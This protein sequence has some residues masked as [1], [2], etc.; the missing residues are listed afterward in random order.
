[1]FKWIK[2]MFSI[3][4][5]VKKVAATEPKVTVRYAP[6][7]KRIVECVVDQKWL[8]RCNRKIEY[9]ILH[10]STTKDGLET[11]DW[12]AIDVYHRS[13]RM[14]YE[15]IVRPIT[16]LVILA[17][18]KAGKQQG[19]IKVGTS[20]FPMEKVEGFY[21][22]AAQ[23]MEKN[24]K[25]GQYMSK[26]VHGIMIQTPWRKVGYNLGIEWADNKVVLRYGR[27]LTENGAHCYQLGINKK[28]IGI[29]TVG[30]FD[31]GYPDSEIWRKNILVCREI[32]KKFPN[33]KILGHREVE[34]VKK[35]C[36]GELWDMG[37]FRID[38]KGMTI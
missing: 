14:Q 3:N 33:V 23:L 31:K 13:F 27:S 9:I 20:W 16:D 24:L 8:S 35:S 34:G 10:H 38:V 29:L 26:Y 32:V 2:K 4:T 11:K 15:I 25:I 18:I 6:K 28:S 36:P 21:L 30:N 5:V 17:D 12:D 37:Q 19:Y 1:M 22:K 7:L